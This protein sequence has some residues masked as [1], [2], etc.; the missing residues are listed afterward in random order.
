M[1]FRQ[2]RNLWEL[3]R[4]RISRVSSMITEF[5]SR[6]ELITGAK[7]IPQCAT[8]RNR[9]YSHSEKLKYWKNISKVETPETQNLKIQNVKKIEFFYIKFLIT[10]SRKISSYIILSKTKKL[11]FFKNHFSKSYRDSF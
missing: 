4:C 1:Q 3:D 2:F 7:S 10:K 8:S 11:L 9:M 6:M 5:R